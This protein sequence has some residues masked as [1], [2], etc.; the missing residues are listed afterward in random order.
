MER[1]TTESILR[2]LADIGF[3]KLPQ[4]ISVQDGELTVRNLD[5]LPP[6]LHGAVASVEKGTGGLKIKLYDKLKAL[7]LLGKALGVF[8]GSSAAEEDNGLL[9]AILNATKD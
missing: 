5:Q 7:E 1:I 4:Y 6:S 3:A 9:Q 8:D 2:E